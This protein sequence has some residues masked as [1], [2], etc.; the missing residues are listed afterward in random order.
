MH[1]CGHFRTPYGSISKKKKKLNEIYFFNFDSKLSNPNFAFFNV[2][3]KGKKE[4]IQLV[5]LG[6]ATAGE[7][8]E[9][10]CS[11][12][13]FTITKNERFALSLSDSTEV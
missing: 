3:E 6:L 12:F 11:C 7:R 2:R 13:T 9:R 5:L 1:L 4:K 10:E 8:P